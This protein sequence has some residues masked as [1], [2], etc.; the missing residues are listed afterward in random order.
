MNRREALL[1]LAALLAARAAA[2]PA[3][4][5]RRIVFFG[6]YPAGSA[7]T[8][9]S[10]AD[11]RAGLRSTGFSEG[12]DYRLDYAWEERVEAVPEK[13]RTA[14]S[15]AGA[16][17]IVAVTTPVAVAAHRQAP[18]VPILFGTVSDPVASGL[19]RSL[20]RPGGNAT[21]LT[22]VLPELS[23]KL[24]QL[25]LEVVPGAKRVAAMWN[26]GNPAKALEYRELAAAAE[27][28]GVE[29]LP[30]PVR[31][32]PEIEKAF[33]ALSGAKAQLLMVLAETLTHVHRDRIAQLALAARLPTVFNF[34]SHVRAGGLLS[35]SPDYS[36]Q[37]RRLGELAGRILAGAKPADLPV[38]QPSRFELAVNLKTAAALGVTIPQTVLLRANEVIR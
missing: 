31:S 28:A 29:V 27:G 26:P 14:L 35:Y 21:G 34:T 37:N 24:L 11:F 16:A 22:N 33:A 9:R 23:G 4:A 10:L 36:G 5:P 32:A 20:A 7:D 13:M 25:A 12:H 19:V 17:L 18:E 6:V 3:K 8:A 2:Q 38:E 1:A 30:H 15:G